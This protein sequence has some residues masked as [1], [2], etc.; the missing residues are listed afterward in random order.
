MFLGGGHRKIRFTIRPNKVPWGNKEK[1]K[2]KIQK[3]SVQPVSRKKWSCGVWGEKGGG[4]GTVGCL[5]QEDSITH[6]TTRPDE[7]L[8]GKG[9][10]GQK[11]KK[12]ENKSRGFFCEKTKKKKYEGKKKG[13]KLVATLRPWGDI[14]DRTGVPLQRGQNIKP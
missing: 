10:T 9:G 7:G 6:G 4:K 3:K 13:K 1:K 5:P 12:S 8:N 11:E 14:R 2:V